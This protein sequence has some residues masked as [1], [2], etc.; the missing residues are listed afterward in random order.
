MRASELI[1]E[2]LAPYIEDP[3][4]RALDPA[5]AGFGTCVYETEDGR[6]CAVGACAVDAKNMTLQFDGLGIA[7]VLE[8]IANDFDTVDHLLQEKY[9]GHDI[10]LWSG[11][12][13]IHDSHSNWNDSGLTKTGTFRYNQL[14]KKWKANENYS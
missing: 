12:Q 4:R 14:I 9:H 13:S 3:S 6:T 2:V 5:G 10:D 1:V 7:E 11:V 8:Q